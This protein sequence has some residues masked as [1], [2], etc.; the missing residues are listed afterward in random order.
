MADATTRERRALAIALAASAV[1]FTFYA[2]RVCP[3]L[4]LTGDSA[5]LVTAAA[6][7]GIPHAPGY[8]LF[9]LIGRAFA[10]LPFGETAWRVHL[11]S[12]L[13]HALAVGATGLAA[14]TMTSSALAAFC[15]G[16]ALAL[17]RSFLLGS[18]YAEVFPLNDLFFALLVLLA[19]RLRQRPGSAVPFALGLGLACAHHMMIALAFPA[20]AILVARPLRT[21]RPRLRAFLALAAPFTLAYALIPIQ[22]ARHPFVSWGGVHDLPSFVE[23]LTRHDYGGLLSAVHGEGHGAGSERCLALGAILTRG[24]GV[25]PLVVAAGGA[26][27]LARSDRALG[28]AL[29]VAALTAGPVFAWRNAVATSTEEGL[30]FFERFSTMCAIPIAVA[31]GAGAGAVADACRSMP[32]R[33]AGGAALAVWSIVAY[34]RVLG[35]DLREDRRGIAFAHDLL[36][37]S[38]DRSLLLLSGDAAGGASLY[39]CGVEHACANRVTI[40]PGTLFMPWAMR[41][42][43]AEHPDV[44]IPWSSGPALARTHELALA[45]VGARPVFAYPDLLAKDPRIADVLVPTP[46]NL[47]FR[48][49]P[50]EETAAR[51]ET[52]LLASARA[53]AN[54]SQAGCEGCGLA[55]PQDHP[56][57]EM[58]L[59]HAY[60]AAAANH[61]RALASLP[62]GEDLAARLLAR[63]GAFAQGDGGGA[64]MSRNVSSS[65]R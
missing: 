47:L 62:D 30:A 29:V 18:L 20:L 41:A 15:A 32:A 28:V 46:D 52:G 60:Q 33:Y 16:A 50:P 12:A 1:V 49:W 39:V 17:E 24:F 26:V 55:S 23:L 63:A 61:A 21:E 4:S 57:Q 54:E 59:V 48:L 35:V 5:E 10:A 6:T 44:T 25:V 31:F 22:A 27:A 2:R 34:S 38:P 51:R 64:S 7:W 11:T 9:I 53:M 8:P 45:N 14:F 37:H 43:R 13:F 3:T 42:A 56:T 19:A 58:Q 65:S 36:L 40:A